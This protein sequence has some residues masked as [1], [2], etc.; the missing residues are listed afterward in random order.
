MSQEAQ[1]YIGVDLYQILLSNYG[2]VG[3]I[4]E[5]PLQGYLG[6]GMLTIKSGFS[7]RG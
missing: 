7:I 2:I 3:A 5:L 6:L 1:N 4:H